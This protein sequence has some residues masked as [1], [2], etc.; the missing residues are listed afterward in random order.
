MTWLNQC[1]LVTSL[2]VMAASPMAFAAKKTSKRVD[3]LQDQLREQ[4]QRVEDL[5]NENLVLRDLAKKKPKTGMKKKA[6][7]KNDV[8]T[9]KTLFDRKK[10]R[11][12]KEFG[13][14]AEKDI[15]SKAIASFRQRDGA[16]LSAA[17]MILQKK[18]PNSVHVDNA[19]YLDAILTMQNK[20]YTPAIRKLET[21]IRSYPKGNKRVSALFAKGIIYKRL[22]LITQSKHVLTQVVK[23]YPGSPESQRA[24]TELRLLGKNSN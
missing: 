1:M 4:R 19:I 23:E 17:T 13:G 18:Y 5:R 7:S 11:L 9:N 14:L 21:V 10:I 20:A 24:V 8:V 22:N 3:Y 15:Y 6:R 2:A 12:V 16:G